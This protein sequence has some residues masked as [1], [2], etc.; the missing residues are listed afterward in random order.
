M[1][2]TRDKKCLIDSS[3]RQ[4]RLSSGLIQRT[5]L[6]IPG[7]IAPAK[8]ANKTISECSGHSCVV[9]VYLFT[10]REE[11]SVVL[12]AALSAISWAGCVTLTVSRLRTQQAV[13]HHNYLGA[14]L[15]TQVANHGNIVLQV[16]G[17]MVNCSIITLF[18]YLFQKYGNH[19]HY[20]TPK[21][22]K[23]FSF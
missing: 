10:L 5:L 14:W 21:K 4:P 6:L 12:P 3:V 15:G 8:Q 17:R 20:F 1:N 16:E 9:V 7:W 22:H 2:Q 23:V 19:L 13:S 18:P 11:S